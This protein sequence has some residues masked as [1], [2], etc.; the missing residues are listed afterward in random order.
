MVII[1][2]QCQISPGWRRVYEYLAP[3]PWLTGS[4]LDL[5]SPTRGMNVA[6]VTCVSSVDA[7]GLILAVIGVGYQ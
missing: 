4:C 2:C 3:G 5:A 6:A 1:S 7:P